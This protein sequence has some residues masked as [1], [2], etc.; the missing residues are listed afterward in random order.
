VKDLDATLA[1]A[2]VSGVSIL[3]T[4]YAGA[5]RNSVIVEFP[6]GYIAELHQLRAQ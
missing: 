2:K 5:D 4:R 3:S 6:G 1:K